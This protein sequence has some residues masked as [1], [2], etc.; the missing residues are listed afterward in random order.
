MITRLRVVTGI[1]RMGIRGLRSSFELIV[2][3]IYIERRN[4]FGQEH[5]AYLTAG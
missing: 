5:G 1:L 4:D 3:P 2:F